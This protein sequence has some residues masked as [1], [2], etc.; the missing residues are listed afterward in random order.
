MPAGTNPDMGPYENDQPVG[1][2]NFEK[3][4]QSS[5]F[6]NPVDAESLISLHDLNDRIVQVEI[7]NGLGQLEMAKSGL[8]SNTYN[9]NSAN[10][11]SGVYFYQLRTRS[12][13]SLNGKFI[14]D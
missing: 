3:D 2:N 7:Y 9:L 6:P 14:I 13:K 12:G 11:K 8:S 10:L 4:N 5:V 1:V